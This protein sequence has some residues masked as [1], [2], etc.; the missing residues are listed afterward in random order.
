MLHYV[1]WLVVNFLWKQLPAVMQIEADESGE[2]E[3]NNKAV[4]HKT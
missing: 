4:G 1:Q 2:S 3:P